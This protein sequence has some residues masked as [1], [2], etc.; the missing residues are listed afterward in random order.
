MLE[1]SLRKLIE[2][3]PDHAHAYNALGYTLADRN[4]R[5]P[6]AQRLIQKALELSPDDAHILDSMGWVLFRQGDI[7]GAI[8]L[9]ERAVELQPQD[10][11]INSHLGDIYWAAGR[12][13][14]AQ[15]QWQRNR[16][17]DC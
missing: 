3:K 2:A 14:E 17:R 7:A 12:K 4:M 1:A 8:Q 15:F 6:E 16:K 9:L 5:L 11:V 13:R 10:A